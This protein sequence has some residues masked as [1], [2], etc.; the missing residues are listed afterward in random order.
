MFFPL[1]LELQSIGP[2]FNTLT[3]WLLLTPLCV[4][5]ILA[6]K[7]NLWEWR[8]GFLSH[9]FWSLGHFENFLKKVAGFLRA[10]PTK[11]YSWGVFKRGCPPFCTGDRRGQHPLAFEK[12]SELMRFI[13]GRKRLRWKAG[14]LFHQK[15][16]RLLASLVPNFRENC[17]PFRLEE[18]MAGS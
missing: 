2:S 4:I 11:P 14:T 10:P 9:F 12:F 3:L 13:A 5:L 8:I 6:P 17:S 18:E 7:G 15:R 1:C 16:V